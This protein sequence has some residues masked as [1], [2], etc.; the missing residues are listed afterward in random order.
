MTGVASNSSSVEILEPPASYSYH[1]H[2]LAVHVL[3]SF[4]PAIGQMRIIQT[5]F[6]GTIHLL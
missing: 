5:C 3:Y 6:S 4:V 2:N 1:P